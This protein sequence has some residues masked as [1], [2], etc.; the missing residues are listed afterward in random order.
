[1]DRV[2][3]QDTV[4]WQP[5]LDWKRQFYWLFWEKPAIGATVYA[6]IDRAA[7]RITIDIEPAHEGTQGEGLAVLLDD[8]LVNMEQPVT[9]ALNGKT[10][11]E[12][13]PVRR[14]EVLVETALTGDPGRVYCAQGARGDV[15]RTEAGLSCHVI[16]RV[17]L[18]Y[19]QRHAPNG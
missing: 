1:M 14:L 18:S 17:P 10:V 6:R 8:T 7:N 9:V 2:P 3:V 15:L 16:R 12:A 5:A 19:R 11:F 13:V 4:V